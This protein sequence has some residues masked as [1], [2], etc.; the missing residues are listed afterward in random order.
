MSQDLHAELSGLTVRRSDI[1]LELRRVQVICLAE[2]I[3]EQL[4]EKESETLGARGWDMLS[5]Q[6]KS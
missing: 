2:R 4:L 5:E 6:D 1:E 3:F